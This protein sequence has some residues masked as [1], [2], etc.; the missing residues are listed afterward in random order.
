MRFPRLLFSICF[1]SVFLACSVE[2]EPINFGNDHCVYC[3]MTIS[4]PKYGAE[5]VTEKGRVYKFDAVEC[6]LPYLKENPETQFSYIM[7]VAYDEPKKLK[8]VEE[9]HFVQ[10]ENFK[11]PMGKNLASFANQPKEF[12]SLKWTQL[13]DNFY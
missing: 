3:K 8:N 13:K 9:L 6:M 11:S 12:E 7:A 2:P 4:D 5:L 1:I 10:N